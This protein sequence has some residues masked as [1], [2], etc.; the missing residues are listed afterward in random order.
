MNK[1]L[2]KYIDGHIQRDEDTLLEIGRIH[3]QLPKSERNWKELTEYLGIDKTPDAYRVWVNKRLAKTG[4]LPVRDLNGKIIDYDSDVEES[5]RNLYKERTKVRDVMNSYRA[6][7]R[8]EA[9]QEIVQEQLVEAIKELPKLPK[10]KAND[11]KRVH[12]SDVEAVLLLSD[13]HIG[14]NCN[15]F[16]NTYNVD[17]V[18]NVEKINVSNNI[19]S[20]I[21]NFISPSKIC[22]K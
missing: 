19:T 8:D 10:V 5:I 9:R 15:N 17:N 16:Y 12:G 18:D 1:D 21:I 4:E 13:L 3:K 11:N 14:V 22:F 20:G 6:S 7:I 2:K